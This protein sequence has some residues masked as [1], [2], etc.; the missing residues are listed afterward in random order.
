MKKMSLKL[1]VNGS[2]GDVE[3]SI[4]KTLLSNEFVFHDYFKE[5]IDRHGDPRYSVVDGS[6]EIEDLEYKDGQG[7]ASGKFM[8]SFYVGCKDINHDGW[9]DVEINFLL[10]GNN[11]II[12]MEFLVDWILDN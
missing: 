8:Y 5:L 11:L 4:V 3:E 10:V 7:V 12:D 9:K 1:P 2:A 6:F